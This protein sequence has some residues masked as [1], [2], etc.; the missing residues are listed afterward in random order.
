[1]CYP[2][3]A[4]KWGERCKA[5]SKTAHLVA[6][7]VT[8]ASQ[9]FIILYD[10]EAIGTKGSIDSKLFLL[11]FVRN[12]LLSCLQTLIPAV[13]AERT[14]ASRY[15]S[16]YERQNRLWISYTIIG[17]A[18]KLAVLLQVL[19]QL[20]SIGKH[21]MVPLAALSLSIT[22]FSLA[23]MIVVHKRDAAKLRDL[24][25]MTGYSKLNNTLSMKF[26]LAENVR[27][28]KWLTY[29]SIAYA[30][31]AFIGAFFAFPPVLVFNESDLVGQ[32]LWEVLNIYF[33]M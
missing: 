28:T 7:T 3:S 1:M 13:A 12:T 25:S 21:T 2:T 11:Y 33:A 24:E 5:Q 9:V 10:L 30:V 6:Y 15:I 20:L 8:Q 29:S 31:W 26:Q 17:S 18:L 14:F 16:D 32:L 23:A 27:V 22:I 4:Q 19:V